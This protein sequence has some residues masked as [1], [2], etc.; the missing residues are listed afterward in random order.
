M[1]APYRAAAAR[2][3]CKMTLA[4]FVARLRPYVTLAVSS[5]MHPEERSVPAQVG[6]VLIRWHSFCCE[7]AN[8]MNCFRS[9][10][11]HLSL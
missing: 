11:N 3:V 10:S 9:H 2:F 4:R 8:E 1:E 6:P 7:S 5:G